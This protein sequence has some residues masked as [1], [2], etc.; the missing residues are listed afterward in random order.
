MTC[1][2]LISPLVHLFILSSLI[3]LREKIAAVILES[4]CPNLIAEFYKRHTWESVFIIQL[5]F[6][7]QEYLSHFS[8]CCKIFRLAL[9]RDEDDSLNGHGGIR[10][11]YHTW[12]HASARLQNHYGAWGY[13]TLWL[14]QDGRLSV[15]SEWIEYS[16]W[17]LALRTARLN[18]NLHRCFWLRNSRG[19]CSFSTYFHY[20]WLVDR[21]C[22][23]SWN[24]NSEL[25]CRTVYLE[26]KLFAGLQNVETL[27]LR[28]FDLEFPRCFQMV[29]QN[30]PKLIVRGLFP[31][32]FLRI[33]SIFSWIFL[34]DEA[35]SWRIEM[36]DSLNLSVTRSLSWC[37]TFPL[38]P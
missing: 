24:T 23:W 12:V 29:K 28:V 22:H 31:F 27:F 15:C 14:V 10:Q 37:R 5:P 4:M 8:A 38:C 9:V 7:V 33:I 13:R 26:V 30:G 20:I 2:C 25:W 17:A 36:R 16:I 35:P 18:F 34:S 32:W 11:P 19:L 3:L 21:R 1:W 6:T